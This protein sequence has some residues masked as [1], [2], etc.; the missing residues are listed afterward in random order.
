MMALLLLMKSAAQSTKIAL[1]NIVD[2]IVMG[3]FGL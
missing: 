2:L 1:R 3:F